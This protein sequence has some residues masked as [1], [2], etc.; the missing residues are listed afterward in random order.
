MGH[1]CLGRYQG[2]PLLL[3][4]EIRLLLV[5]SQLLTSDKQGRYQL[6]ARYPEPLWRR[7]PRCAEG[8]S[9]APD[10][11]SHFSTNQSPAF[12]RPS[13]N[14]KRERQV[15]LARS[16]GGIIRR[17]TSKDNYMYIVCRAHGWLF[18]CLVLPIE[19]FDFTLKTDSTDVCSVTTLIWQFQP[20]V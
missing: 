11:P 5:L 15:Y 20:H 18:V 3:I 16:R 7:R 12:G 4:T 1:A 13:T 10:P 6:Y 9:A 8:C 14:Q 19:R 2:L 17:R